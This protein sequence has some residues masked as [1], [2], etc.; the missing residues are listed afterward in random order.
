MLSPL[1]QIA[2]TYRKFDVF[3]GR[4]AR[5]EF[6]CFNLA[7]AIPFAV[8]LCAGFLSDENLKDATAGAPFA[9]KLAAVVL[10]IANFLP[11]LTL[12]VRRLHDTGR[13]GKWAF[14]LAPTFV[15][16]FTTLGDSLWGNYEIVCTLYLA[17]PAVLLI[18]A[19][20]KGQHGRNLYGEQPGVT[21]G[22]GGGVTGGAGGAPAP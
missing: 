19:S 9:L 6:W 21:G 8:L 2:A 10:V 17:G 20:E 15:T 18:F 14:L 1:Q 12:L 11:G 7:N 5:S 13:S 16:Y 22:G 4:A 3:N